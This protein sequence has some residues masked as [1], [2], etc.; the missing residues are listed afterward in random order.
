[1][2]LVIPFTGSSD[3]YEE[4]STRLLKLGGLG[5]HRLLVP[6]PQHLLSQAEVFVSGVRNQFVAADL[7]PA[8]IADASLIWL[9]REGLLAASMVKPGMQ[10]IPSAPVLW[11]DPGFV[12]TKA[13][14]ADGIQSA[15]FNAGGGFRILASWRRSV[16]STHGWEPTGPVVF[17]SGWISECEMLSRINGGS[18]S[19]K[20]Y[21]QY[22]FDDVRAESPLLSDSKDSLIA[23]FVPTPETAATPPVRRVAAVRTT[24]STPTPTP[25][26]TA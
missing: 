10:E 21:F 6:T 18:Y 24:P 14:W 20:E 2:I 5:G 16:D 4:L 13:D 1:M 9:F 11:L 19:W 7:V 3:Y 26:P 15:F 12:P 8:N 22:S 17:P 23:E 25:T